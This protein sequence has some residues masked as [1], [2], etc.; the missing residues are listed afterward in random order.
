MQTIFCR[1]LVV[2]LLLLSGF[3][4]YGFLETFEPLAPV[5]QWIWRVIYVVM[6]SSCL[7]ATARLWRTGCRGASVR[8]QSRARG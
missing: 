6:A 1:I 7:W 5:E 4:L 3:C 2:P 8:K